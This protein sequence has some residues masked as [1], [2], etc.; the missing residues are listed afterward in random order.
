[1]L[2]EAVD[3]LPAPLRLMAGYHYGWWD[4]TGRPTPGRSGKGLRAALVLAAAAA[5]GIV[6]PTVVSAAASIEMLHNWTLIHDDVIDADEM[7][8]GRPTVWRVWGSDA[9]LVLGDAM[10]AMTIRMLLDLPAAQMAEA[11]DR[12]E[13]V[14][15]ELCRGQYE[16]CLF[17]S[18]PSVTVGEYMQMV[19]G[20]TG[21]LMGCACALG[22]LCAYADAATIGAF[23]SFGRE[24]G[25]AFQAA[26]DV[27]G[28]VGDPAVTGKPV[29]T[30]LIRRKRSLPVVAALESGASAAVDLDELYRSAAPMTNTEV[31]QAT[32]LVA[33]CGGIDWAQQH[34]QLRAQSALAA[35]PAGAAT[36]ELAALT[37]AAVRRV[38]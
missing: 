10:H 5:C 21:A 27:L 3:Q 14:T 28:I 32:Q 16:D 15:V 1:M 11:V 29:G 24:L 34:A 25:A 4:S 33:A 2:R 6:G 9:A 35:L 17:E 23:D 13:T 18:R 38:Q 12:L 19:G 22:A 36:A 26:D 8:H 31:A 37:Q 30:D 7:R 20:K